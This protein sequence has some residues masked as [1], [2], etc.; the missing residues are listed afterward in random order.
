MVAARFSH[1]LSALFIRQQR[2]HWGAVTSARP[3]RSK[4]TV[5]AA[6][7]FGAEF[8][9]NAPPNRT[10]RITQLTVLGLDPNTDPGLAG[11]TGASRD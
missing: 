6:L 5:A 8:A 7:E 10:G 2:S 4:I 1:E 9:A 3:K 11:E